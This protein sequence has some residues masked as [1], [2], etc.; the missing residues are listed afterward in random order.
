[1][2]PHLPRGKRPYR[3]GVACEDCGNPDASTSLS[4]VLVCDRC[5]DI[6]I[7]EYTGFPRLPDPPPPILLDGPDGRTHGLRFKVWRVPTGIEVQLEEMEVPVGEGYRF[8]VLGDHDADVDD[9]VTRVRSIANSEIRRLYL[10]PAPNRDGWTLRDDEVAG[11]L[12]WNDEG[13]HGEPYRVIID[14]RTLSWEEFGMALESYEGWRFRLVIE[15]SIDDART[16]ADI[17]ELSGRASRPEPT[18]G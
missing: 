8:A 18:D 14:G 15:D 9:L 4:N 3:V 2:L 10:E 12:I 1:M 11:Q 7:A 16:D 13:G 17:I 5:Y 6:R